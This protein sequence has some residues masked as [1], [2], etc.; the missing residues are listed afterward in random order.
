[1]DVAE[2]WKTNRLKFSLRLGRPT[3]ALFTQFPLTHCVKYE[4]GFRARK[5][6][7][8][9]LLRNIP[10]FIVV[11]TCQ[12]VNSVIAVKAYQKYHLQVLTPSVASE[13]DVVVRMLLGGLLICRQTLLFYWHQYGFYA[14]VL[15]VN[16]STCCI[17]VAPN[18]TD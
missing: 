4:S 17:A 12:T 8:R 2:S 3:P 11:G 9:L 14:S 5:A 1:M 15:F 18:D 6:L 10:G 13:P 16:L 7:I